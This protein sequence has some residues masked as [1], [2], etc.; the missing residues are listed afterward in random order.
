[1]TILGIS[2]EIVTI[3]G[4]KVPINR[5]RN[6][7]ALEAGLGRYFRF[8]NHERPQQSLAYCTP[9]EVHFAGWLWLFLT[10]FSPIRGLD[11]GANYTRQGFGESIDWQVQARVEY[12]RID[13]ETKI[14]VSITNDW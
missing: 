4:I 8:Y 3:D 6:I 14:W 9:V 5:Q 13:T 12:Q 11:N 7:L 10:L 2:L 1:M